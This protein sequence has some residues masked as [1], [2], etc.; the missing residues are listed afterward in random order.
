MSSPALAAAARRL[1]PVS[2]AGCWMFG[3]REVVEEMEELEDD[4]DVFATERGEGVFA[5][6]VDPPPRDDHEVLTRPPM[7]RPTP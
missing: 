2:R 7:R 6:P 4:A 1:V 5:R 3:D